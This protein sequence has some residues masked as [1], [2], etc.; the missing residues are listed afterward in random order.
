[1]YHNIFLVGSWTIASRLTGFLRD[2]ALAALMGG[3]ALDDAYVA[4]IKLPNQF[5]QIFGEGSFNSAYL[6]T[7]TRVL[8]SAG[9]QEASRFASHVFTLVILSQI[10]LL[11]IVYL[12]MPLLVRLTSPGF[13]SQSEKFGQAV[14]MSR[15]MRPWPRCGR[16]AVAY[17]RSGREPRSGRSRECASAPC[18][19]PGWGS[20]AA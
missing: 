14:A 3:G 12:D 15:I 7:S 6:P 2:M 19:V 10:A 8:E 11:G 4:A 1:M 9:P 5:R 20:R 13:V 16:A 18:G 17:P